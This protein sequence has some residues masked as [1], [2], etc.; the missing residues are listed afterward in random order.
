MD[1]R[2]ARSE[3][4]AGD[5]TVRSFRKKPVIVDA[6]QF[7]GTYDCAGKLKE[8]GCPIVWATFPMGTVFRIETL[9]GDMIVDEGD[10]VIKGVAGEF[11]PCKPEI[12]AATYEEICAT[13]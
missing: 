3:I 5:G 1:R 13:S 7:D 12:F 4:R 10:W 2:V 8:W 6:M 11:F 9:E